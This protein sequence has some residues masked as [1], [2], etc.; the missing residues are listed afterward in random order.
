MYDFGK[1]MHGP[2]PSTA[3]LVRKAELLFA[4]RCTF[5][6]QNRIRSG[7]LT[8]SVIH[9]LAITLNHIFKFLHHLSNQESLEISVHV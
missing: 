8:V 5:L 1:K 2:V 4:E 6:C 3:L 7:T 9:L